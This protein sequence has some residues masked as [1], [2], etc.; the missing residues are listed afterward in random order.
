MYEKLLLPPV[1][2]VIALVVLRRKG[3]T[4]RRLA[5]CM[6][7]VVA[8]LVAWLVVT[9]YFH[10][11]PTS[12]NIHRWVGIMIVSIVLLFVPFAVGVALQQN[13]RGRPVATISQVLA[14]LFLLGFTYL[15]SVTG[16]LDPSHASN[17]TDEN[18]IR[19]RVLHVVA[20]PFLITIILCS[21]L[22][23]FRRGKSGDD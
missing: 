18:Q 17:I 14:L 3:E 20:L 7:V 4:A 2:A 15:A 6:A 9:G 11:N 12:Q 5:Q 10:A 1:I 13:I 16:Y 19:F 21:S 8:A 22:W 23:F